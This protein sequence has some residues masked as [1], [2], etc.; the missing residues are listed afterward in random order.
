MPRWAGEA[1]AD[2]LIMIGQVNYA[3]SR[4]LPRERE[5]RFEG[6]GTSDWKDY[7]TPT[8]RKD[9]HLVGGIGI[10]HGAKY[11]GHGAAGP[12]PK[13]GGGR[14]TPKV[15]LTSP[16]PSARTTDALGN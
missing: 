2:R 14:Q 9:G 6:T 4:W 1:K 7:D 11:D 10:E 8:R 15:V 12:Q 5:D 13:E 3:G 16:R